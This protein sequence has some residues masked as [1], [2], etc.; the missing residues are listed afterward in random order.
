MAHFR[1]CSTCESYS[2]AS[3]YH[4]A[5]QL[6]SDQLELTFAR[7]RYSLGIHVNTLLPSLRASTIGVPRAY[8]PCPFPGPFV[9]HALQEM[10]K[11]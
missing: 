10:R 8:S 7:F 5:L 11:N 2:Q 6:I 9:T 4:Y 1:A 3:F